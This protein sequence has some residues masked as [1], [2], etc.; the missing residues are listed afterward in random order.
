MEQ[1]PYNHPVTPANKPVTAGDSLFGMALAQA[2]M[3][4]VYGP[5]ASM[6]WEA[7]EIASAVC[8]DRRA[9]DRSNSV[10][11]VKKSLAG[12]FARSSEQTI[13]E[14]ERAFFRPFQPACAPAFSKI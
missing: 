4:V 3:G 13:A 8:E 12:I 2:F 1:R 7:G 10:M 14:A 5:C 11:G 6:L 9:N